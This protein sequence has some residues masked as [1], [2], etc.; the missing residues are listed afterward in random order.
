[1]VPACYSESATEDFFST[2]DK[3]FEWQYQIS[4]FNFKGG[5]K[6]FISTLYQKRLKLHGK[7]RA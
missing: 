3:H 1:M 6:G 5:V 2:V 7:V 4:D